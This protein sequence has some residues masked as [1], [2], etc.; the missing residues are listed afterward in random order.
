M[1]GIVSANELAPHAHG[2][3]DAGPAFFPRRAECPPVGRDGPV[4]CNSLKDVEYEAA[5]EPEE[6]SS[7]RPGGG[8]A[9][10]RV[11]E[12][13]CQICDGRCPRIFLVV[14]AL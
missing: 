2:L 8:G 1:F 3:F 6:A 9:P 11:P 4:E 7:S 10:F 12:Q 5:T 13:G 14:K